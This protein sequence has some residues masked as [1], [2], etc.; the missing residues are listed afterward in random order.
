LTLTG[1]DADRIS[2][3][4]FKQEIEIGGKLP[5]P[6]LILPPPL[7]STEDDG[8]WGLLARDSG[9]DRG[10]FVSLFV[11]PKLRSVELRQFEIERRITFK[12][13]DGKPLIGWL[14]KVP[15]QL[16]LV[17]PQ[18]LRFTCPVMQCESRVTLKV[19]GAQRLLFIEPLIPD[20]DAGCEK[21]RES[22]LVDLRAQADDA[23][24]ADRSN[25]QLLEVGNLKTA[26][27]ESLRLYELLSNP[28]RYRQWLRI[29]KST[30]M[31]LQSYGD[32]YSSGS[33]TP[34]ISV[35]RDFAFRNL[36]T[37]GWDVAAAPHE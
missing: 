11:S 24:S 22:L 10:V 1:R 6:R 18:E 29:L 26:G 9:K 21:M 31:P 20:D 12:S 8:W 25:Y 7:A 5:A 14:H 3:F 4:V 28:V 37:G 19:D 15:S 34:L 27:V 30:G 23:L 2:P 17:T 16:H 32:D 33:I 36:P 13:T 35:T